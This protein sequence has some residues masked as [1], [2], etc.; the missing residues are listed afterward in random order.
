HIKWFYI[1]ETTTDPNER[2]DRMENEEFITILAYLLYNRSLKVPNKIIGFFKRNNEVTCRLQY[3]SGLSDF[4]QKLE[5]EANEKNLFIK[6]IKDVD[7]QIIELER[8]LDTED[9]DIKKLKL[10]EM[11]NVSS[12][13]TYRRSLQDFY[14]LWLKLANYPDN[15]ISVR[16]IESVVDVLKRFRNVD[17]FT[18]DNSYIDALESE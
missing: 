12:K 7:S 6:S 3:K 5:N 11:L 4:L 16:K 15:I 10:N 9:I 2:R 17:N 1:K 14:I 13:P 8:Y 18:V